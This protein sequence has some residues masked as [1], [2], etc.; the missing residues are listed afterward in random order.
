MD[1][2]RLEAELRALPQTWRCG[3][4][5]AADGASITIAGLGAK[6]RIGDQVRLALDPRAEGPTGEIIALDGGEA[7]AMVL[8]PTKG[9]ALDDLVWLIP[10]PKLRPCDGWVG[11]VID[12]FGQP[13][14]DKPLPNGPVAVDIRAPAPAATRRERLGAQIATGLAVTDTL[15]PI[16]RGQR[17]GVFSGSGV[18]K[19]QLL[20]GLARG[21]EADI[22]VFAL[23]GE[24]G[25]DL[26]E[27]LDRGLG[28]EA[29]ARSVVLAATSDQSALLRR[30][31]LWSAMA[32]AEHFRSHGKHVLLIVDS[33][34]RFAE[35]HR[36]VALTAGEPPTLRAFPP[37]TTNLIASATERAGP[38]EVGQGAIT[39][40]F[41]V[42]VAGSDMEEP[43]ADITR[44]LLDGHIVLEREI[45]ERGRFP[46]IDAVRSVSRSLPWVVG[47]EEGR[48]INR[49][50]ALLSA[51]EK[52]RPM[53]QTGLYVAGS[54]PAVDAAVA[55]F[56]RLDAFIAEASPSGPAASFARLAELLDEGADEAPD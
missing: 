1:L 27:F 43:I 25:R 20:S 54:D 32:V 7:R 33:L 18:G 50:R 55:A 48:L 21:V 41:S 37:S 11:R 4:V 35:A 8:D 28:P 22:V 47:E 15:L 12:A 52:A 6:A 46:A 53:V 26:L 45:A 51:Y 19:S 14:D 10:E 29:R 49:A 9:V 24:R 3:R 34:T 17:I 23:I 30:R 39:A 5:I 40:I 42:L 56:E 31:A 38:G 13:L 44:G 36:E 16:A 2:A